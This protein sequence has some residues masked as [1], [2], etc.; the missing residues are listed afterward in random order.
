MF[1]G[2]GLFCCAW[3]L[4]AASSISLRVHGFEPAGVRS[5]RFDVHETPIFAAET[6]FGFK[7]PRFGNVMAAQH[8]FWS[9]G[10]IS[11]ALFVLASLNRAG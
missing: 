6:I 1:N 10:L 7:S 4:S 2:A 3:V 5:E 8:L 9:C 11:F